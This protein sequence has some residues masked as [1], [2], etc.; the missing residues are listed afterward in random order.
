MIKNIILDIGDVLVKSDFR[1]FFAERGYTGEMGETLIQNT[2]YSPVWHDLDSGRF[3]F[4]EILDAF[5]RNAP[6][7]EPALRNVFQDMHGFVHEYPYA[8]EWILALRSRDLKVFCLSNWSEKVYTDCCGEL[9][10]LELT[11]GYILS[12]RVKTAKPEP[13][14]YEILL[15]RYRL[16]VDECIFVDDN[17]ENV[18]VAESMGI[19]GVVFRDREQADDEIGRIMQEESQHA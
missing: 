5:V 2:F 7:L 18:R 15:N 17:P 10:F 9:G 19:H 6:E 16:Q 1:A 14:I 3:T 12:W 13:E 4:T 11:D 8:R